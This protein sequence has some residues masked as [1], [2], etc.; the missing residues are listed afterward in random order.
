LNT[1]RIKIDKSFVE[2]V[3]IDSDER[4]IVSMIINFGKNLKQKIL[5][6]GVENQAQLAA[7]ATLGCDEVQGYLFSRP[8]PH[9]EITD[10]LRHRP[11]VS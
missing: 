5:A 9:Q 1:S 7:L 8:K 4:I 10:L 11:L 6:E 3:D 2:R